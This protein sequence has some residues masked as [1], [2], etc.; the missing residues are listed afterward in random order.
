VLTHGADI[1]HIE[2]DV[3]YPEAHVIHEVDELVQPMQLSS[4][5][6]QSAITAS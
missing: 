1:T 6:S 4:H 2:P 3:T 5:I